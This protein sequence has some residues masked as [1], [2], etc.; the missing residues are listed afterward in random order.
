MFGNEK[1]SS[2]E[3]ILGSI[4]LIL[5]VNFLIFILESVDAI[6]IILEF[7]MLSYPTPSSVPSSFPSSLFHCGPAT[8]C[9]GVKHFR[10]LIFPFSHLRHRKLM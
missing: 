2:F 8:P 9:C 10:E 7:M 1:K 6:K 3:S 4:N 5:A